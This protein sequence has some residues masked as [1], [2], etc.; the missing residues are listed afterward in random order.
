MVRF[1]NLKHRVQNIPGY[2]KAKVK[3]KPF[4]WTMTRKQMENKQRLFENQI[5]FREQASK[6]RKILGDM[7][8]RLEAKPILTVNDKLY[9]KEYCLSPENLN[10]GEVNLEAIEIPVGNTNDS[11]SNLPLKDNTIKIANQSLSQA[12]AIFEQVNETIRRFSRTS[13]SHSKKRR[14]AMGQQFAI[15]EQIM[16]GK[17][18][19][20]DVLLLLERKPNASALAE[21]AREMIQQFDSVATDYREIVTY[22]KEKARQNIRKAIGTK[23]L[24]IADALQEL[25]GSSNYQDLDLL[26]RYAAILENSQPNRSTRVKQM[27][28]SRYGGRRTHKLRR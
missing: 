11:S 8:D 25:R 28:G 7:C 23:N 1:E 10:V 13:N 12:G 9:L 24:N 19:C 27:L 17:K 2:L 6:R 4:H 5:L 22:T 14:Q 3:G 20:Q 18:L 26:G 21:S 16:R 15:E